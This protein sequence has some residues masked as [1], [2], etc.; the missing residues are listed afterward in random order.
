VNG[1]P[2]KQ[3]FSRFKL[4][5]QL[6]LLTM[7]LASAVSAGTFVQFRTL[8]GDIAVE[9]YDQDKPAT[10]QNF[11]HY[12]QTGRY[13]NCFSN[14][15]LPNFVL[16][17][18]AYGVTNRGATNAAIV[19]IPRY[20]AVSNEF[21]RGKFYSNVFGTL[22]MAKPSGNPDSATSE[23]FFNLT[24]NAAALDDTNNN[25]GFTVFGHVIAGTNVLAK[26]NAF[27]YWLAPWASLPQATN[28][29]L[30]Q[31]YSPP[32]D[33]LPLLYPSP[34]PTNFVYLDIS[35]LSLQIAPAPNNRCEVTWNSAA[36]LTNYVEYATNL[37]PVWQRLWATNGN[38]TMMQFQDALT[39]PSPRF[40]RVRVA[41]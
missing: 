17:A 3:C 26:F 2:I 35:L 8:Y 38:G 36:G 19:G 39:N 4:A 25:G 14:R 40:Y 6:W 30:H 9:L 22:A 33:D 29:V 10:V 15:L 31:Y 12:V 28:L 1:V 7:V 41:N 32:F 34:V 27:Q 37:P 11:L 5:C 20:G 18:G 13:T 21:S 24:N 23:F 16:Q